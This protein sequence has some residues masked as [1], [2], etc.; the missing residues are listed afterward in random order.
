[1]IPEPAATD[2]IV[3]RRAAIFHYLELRRARNPVILSYT[4]GIPFSARRPGLELMV[5][6]DSGGE[7]ELNWGGLQVDLSLLL[8][9]QVD[10]LT[11]PTLPP[12]QRERML[13]RMRPL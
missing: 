11:E 9:Y 8:G 13:A 4:P 1:M 5:E 6:F 12:E 2:T 10:I 3:T 7:E